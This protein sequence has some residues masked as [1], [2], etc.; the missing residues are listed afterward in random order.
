MK[1][2]E[3]P[4]YSQLSLK[5]GSISHLCSLISILIHKKWQLYICFNFN[6]N[7]FIT[8][9]KINYLC[10]PIWVWLFIQF[11]IIINQEYHLFI[12]YFYLFQFWCVLYKF[13]QIADFD[14]NKLTN[15]SFFNFLFP[16]SEIIWFV[17][18]SS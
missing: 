8:G 7:R 15:V 12:P 1:A 4:K 3:M 17:M 14:I 9:L 16:S 6:L 2:N 10:Q 5:F 11:I 18:Y 13:R